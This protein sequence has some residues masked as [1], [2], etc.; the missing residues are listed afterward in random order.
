M[1]LHLLKNSLSYISISES[2]MLRGCDEIEFLSLYHYSVTLTL[3]TI[4]LSG[5]RNRQLCRD[6]SSVRF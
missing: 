5:I 6:V 4:G 3:D 2:A 1:P